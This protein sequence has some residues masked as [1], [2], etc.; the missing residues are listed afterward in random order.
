MGQVRFDQIDDWVGS[1]RGSLLP[2]PISMYF[3]LVAA[4]GGGLW[5]FSSE[6]LLFNRIFVG[7]SNVKH[8]RN[9]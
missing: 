9:L 7:E 3:S 4:N 8:A 6:G 1:S 5:K 2:I